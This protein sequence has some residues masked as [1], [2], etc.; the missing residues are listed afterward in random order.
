MISFPWLAAMVT[1]WSA[2]ALN[3]DSALNVTVYVPGDRLTV[4][5]LACVALCPD[6]FHFAPAAASSGVSTTVSAP[7]ITV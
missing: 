6:S 3:P 4:S 7:G 2:G 1:D 5:P